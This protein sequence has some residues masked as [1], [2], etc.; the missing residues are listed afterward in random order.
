ML[1]GAEEGGR[2]PWHPSLLDFSLRQ[3]SSV[4][5]QLSQSRALLLPLDAVSNRSHSFSLW[6]A[7]RAEPKSAQASQATQP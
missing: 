7:G 6:G 4:C 1:V 2:A 5:R 3:S